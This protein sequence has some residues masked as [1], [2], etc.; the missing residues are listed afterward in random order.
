MQQTWENKLLST[1]I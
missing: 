1:C